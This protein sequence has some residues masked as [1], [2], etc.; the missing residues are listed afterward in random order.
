MI[1]LM[2]TAL[3]AVI[4]LSIALPSLTRITNEIRF[5]SVRQQLILDLTYTRSEA[6]NQGGQIVICPSS[7]I[8]ANLVSCS[9]DLTR[10]SNGWI[11]FEDQDNNGIFNPPLDRT[12]SNPRADQDDNLLK[13]SQVDSSAVITWEQT[14]SISFDGEGQATSSGTF[15]I[16]DSLGDTSIAK[17]V[18]V[19][20]SGRIRS[21]D[22]VTCP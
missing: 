2:I 16:C 10:W 11:I 8:E 19:I 4:V 6:V 15:K 18:S 5:N 3:I 17:G 12:S 7:S 14:N 9:A 21:T 13:T 1:E 20:L 22:S